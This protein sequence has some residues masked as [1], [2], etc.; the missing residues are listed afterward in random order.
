MEANLANGEQKQQHMARDLRDTCVWAAC[1][2]LVL[3][4]GAQTADGAGGAPHFTEA[5]SKI[6]WSKVKM[7]HFTQMSNEVKMPVI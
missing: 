6:E 5:Q 7:L 2:A 4:V 3:F 1:W